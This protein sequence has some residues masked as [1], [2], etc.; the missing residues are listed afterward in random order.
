MWYS[1]ELLEEPGDFDVN[2]C[3]ELCSMSSLA[4]SS[5]S[6]RRRRF[7]SIIVGH[8]GHGYTPQMMPFHGRRTHHH[9]PSRLQVTVQGTMRTPKSTMPMAARAS[10]PSWGLKPPDGGSHQAEQPRYQMAEWTP[11]TQASSR[12]RSGQFVSARGLR[13][14]RLRSGG[15]CWIGGGEW[16]PA[17]IASA[18]S[19][20]NNGAAVSVVGAPTCRGPLLLALVYWVGFGGML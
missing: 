8:H 10:G 3:L 17:T 4:S 7:I 16:K 11:A 2:R 12:L 18:P 9:A 1:C 15:A 14:L 5:S 6:V 20:G 13:R 19:R